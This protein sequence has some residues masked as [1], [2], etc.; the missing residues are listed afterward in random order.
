M[1][2]RDSG[3]G[4]I[5]VRYKVS[6]IVSDGNNAVVMVIDDIAE[7]KQAEESLR[8]SEIKYHRLHEN[9]TDALVFIDMAG[10]PPGL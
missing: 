9:M 3:V 1:L 4:P 8:K 6:R 10:L 2:E 5:W 7:R